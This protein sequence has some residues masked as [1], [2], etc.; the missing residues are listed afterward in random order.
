MIHDAALPRE[1]KPKIWTLFQL[2]LFMF[3]FHLHLHLTS[4]FST[5]PFL[6]LSLSLSLSP[7]P[8]KEVQ[9]E[10][11]LISIQRHA[12]D[13]QNTDWQD[14]PNWTG[15]ADRH[16]RGCQGPCRAIRG[17]PACL[18]TLHLCTGE[19]RRHELED[20]GEL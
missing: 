18:P 20:G 10:S 14:R 15:P 5:L 16:D 19:S 13:C 9:K 17:D 2:L 4:L 11:P 6:A 1:R 12:G 7:P 8:P 3:F